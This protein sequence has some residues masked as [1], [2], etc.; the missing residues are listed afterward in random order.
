[1]TRAML[2]IRTLGLCVVME[3]TAFALWIYQMCFSVIDRCN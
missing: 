2:E 3:V 1:M